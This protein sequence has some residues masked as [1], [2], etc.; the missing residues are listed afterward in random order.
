MD[1]GVG[2][3]LGT[4]FSCVAVCDSNGTVEVLP[5]AVGNRTTPS[6]VGFT[7]TDILIGE[8]AKHLF[9]DDCTNIVYGEIFIFL[10]RLEINPC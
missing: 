9:Y 1:Y 2:I 3:D 6:F 8:G 10:P 5:N 4:T 7:N